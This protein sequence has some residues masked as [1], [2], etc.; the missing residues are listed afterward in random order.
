MVY[1]YIKNRGSLAVRYFKL[2]YFNPITALFPFSLAHVHLLANA[3]T[4]R[5]IQVLM[6]QLVER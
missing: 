4:R 5:E 6:V 2:R 3:I 1:G